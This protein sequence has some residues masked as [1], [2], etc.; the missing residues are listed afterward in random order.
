MS[1]EK[2]SSMKDLALELVLKERRES[3][4]IAT[5]MK[6]GDNYIYNII[7]TM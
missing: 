6:P 5:N 1:L 3:R 2:E 7:H 4:K